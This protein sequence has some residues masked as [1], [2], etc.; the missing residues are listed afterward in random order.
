MISVVTN[1]K[2]LELRGLSTDNKPVN[3]FVG[4]G[5][6]FLEMDTANVYMFDGES[7]TWKLL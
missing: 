2:C 6:I 1:D 4:N 5:S 3:D 7:K